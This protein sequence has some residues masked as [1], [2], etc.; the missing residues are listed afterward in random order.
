MVT[1][2]ISVSGTEGVRNLGGYSIWCENVDSG[3]SHR[4][5]YAERAALLVYRGI[6]CVHETNS[7]IVSELYE[8]RNTIIDKGTMR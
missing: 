1:V 8:G 5:Q 6:P 3:H 4:T 7:N 2:V